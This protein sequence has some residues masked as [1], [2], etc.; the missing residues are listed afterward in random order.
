[1]DLNKFIKN[2]LF[3]TIFNTEK[4]PKRKYTKRTYSSDDY[5]S[6]YDPTWLYQMNLPGEY[7]DFVEL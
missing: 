6:Y 7:V 5:D 1:M 4:K 3:E 2:W